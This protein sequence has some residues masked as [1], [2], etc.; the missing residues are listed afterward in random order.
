[1]RIIDHSKGPAEKIY[2]PFQQRYWQW[3]M[4]ERATEESSCNEPPAPAQ[5]ELGSTQPLQFR[6][7]VKTRNRT[8]LNISEGNAPTLLANN[9]H[10]LE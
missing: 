3:P 10:P 4:N 6:T 9:P 5:L 1:M 7:T 8:I 2:L